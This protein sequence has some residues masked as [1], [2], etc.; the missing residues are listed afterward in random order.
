MKFFKCN[1]E[2][3]KNYRY[4]LGNRIEGQGTTGAQLRIFKWRLN[5]VNG[6]D[7][8][9]RQGYQHLQQIMCFQQQLSTRPQTQSAHWLHKLKK[10]YFPLM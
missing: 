4:G 1:F 10:C 9:L 6:F 5:A 2:N 8:S 7:F 3:S